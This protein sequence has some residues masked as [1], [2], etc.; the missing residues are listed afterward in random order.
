MA[1][2]A[3]LE[4]ANQEL[5]QQVEAAR[6]ETVE[7][8]K[9]VAERARELAEEHS[10][11]GVVEEALLDLGISGKKAMDVLVTVSVPITVDENLTEAQIKE[12]FLRVT[13]WGNIFQYGVGNVPDLHEFDSEAITLLDAESGYDVKVVAS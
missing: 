8:G 2:K 12:E 6:A 5:R 1:T 4:S 7:L 10:W 13:R 9:R 11:C 3:E